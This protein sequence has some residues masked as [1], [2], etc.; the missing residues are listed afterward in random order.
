MT[1]DL[2]DTVDLAA[3]C[4]F[5]GAASRQAFRELD[6]P[7]RSRIKGRGTLN[8][9]ARTRSGADIDSEGDLVLDPSLGILEFEGR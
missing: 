1:K 9:A 2:K 4:T 8:H 5:L 6:T 7:C 3:T